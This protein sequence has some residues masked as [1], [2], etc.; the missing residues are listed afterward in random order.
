MVP[1][2]RMHSDKLTTKT[3][4]T[5]K[6]ITKI[7]YFNPKKKNGNKKLNLLKILFIIITT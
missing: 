2:E 6:K 1:D 3:N 7:S 4:Q 5:K